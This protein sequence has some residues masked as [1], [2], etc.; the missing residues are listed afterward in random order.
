[1]ERERGGEPK[2]TQ[3]HKRS[4]AKQTPWKTALDLLYNKGLCETG[5]HRR[6]EKK[7]IRAALEAEMKGGMAVE[8]ITRTFLAEPGDYRWGVNPNSFEPHASHQ[9]IDSIL[10]TVGHKV[11]TLIDQSPKEYDCYNITEN[12]ENVR[13]PKPW[14]VNEE[15]FSQYLFDT[16]KPARI[17]ALEL[18][19]N[20]G[21]AKMFPEKLEE[22]I[23]EA[24]K[25]PEDYNPFS[26][27]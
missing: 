5:A 4:K 26:E 21:F 2:I 24:K 27:S 8:T 3:I 16:Y 15:T 1:M 22:A 9:R 14:T 18:H 17:K 13:K 10:L 25:L 11:Y 20:R 7:M 23:E 12:G 19:R 6:C